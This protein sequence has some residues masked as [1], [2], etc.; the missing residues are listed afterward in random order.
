MNN[1]SVEKI[2]LIT[3]GIV[4]RR[5]NMCVRDNDN[6]IIGEGSAKSKKEAEQKAA[7][8]ALNV[9]WYIQWILIQYIEF[10][11]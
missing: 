1:I 9:F 11:L 6:K 4:N 8:N 7:K 10:Y 2:L 3:N 5:F